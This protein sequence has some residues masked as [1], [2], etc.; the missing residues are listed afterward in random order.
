MSKKDN[1]PVIKEHTHLTK[2]SRQIAITDKILAKI[3]KLKE[4][5]NILVVDDE[6]NPREVIRKCLKEEGYNVT[7]ADNGDEALIIFR[8]KSFDLVTTCIRMPGMGGITLLGKLKKISYK[9]PV[10]IITAYATL[11]Q[12]RMAVRYNVFDIMTKPF[13]VDEIKKTVKKA[14]K[15]KKL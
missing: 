10:I 3:S 4:K 11:E 7:T 13:D 2:A 6:L 12:A 1:L 5:I 15:T 9:T 14:L 8:K